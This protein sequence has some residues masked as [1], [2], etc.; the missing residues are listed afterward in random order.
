MRAVLLI[1]LF[2]SSAATASETLLHIRAISSWQDDLPQRSLA[3]YVRASYEIGWLS[4]VFLEQNGWNVKYRRWQQKPYWNT[5]PL[6]LLKF[7]AYDAQQRVTD[8]YTAF[9]LL[10]W[11]KGTAASG[12]FDATS[13]LPTVA[14]RLSKRILE[15]LR[16]GDDVYLG[17]FLSRRPCERNSDSNLRIRGRRDKKIHITGEQL[18]AMHQLDCYARYQ[19]PLEAKSLSEMLSTEELR[20]IESLIRMHHDDWQ[21]AKIRQVRSYVSAQERDLQEMNHETSKSS[22]AEQILQLAHA[23]IMLFAFLKRKPLVAASAGAIAAVA[24]VLRTKRTWD[25]YQ[26]RRVEFQLANKRE[27]HTLIYNLLLNAAAVPVALI[28]GS[29]IGKVLG[30]AKR[31]SWRAF[32]RMNW[33]EKM[34]G[35][36]FITSFAL[37][38]GIDAK[39]HLQRK[40][41][42]LK[43]KNFA[44]NTSYNVLGAFLN[45]QALMNSAT[46]RGRLMSMVAISIAY[47]YG[48]IYTQELQGLLGDHWNGRNIQWDEVFRDRDM[49]WRRDIIHC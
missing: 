15:E 38:R 23:P 24:Y 7:P 14:S 25:E 4:H 21:K 31:T 16:W 8:L 41:N 12:I 9:P 22:R 13:R 18:N 40:E 6:N 19:L 47:S 10:Q 17:S 28:G 34:A 11:R 36:D 32:S 48:N 46:W 33:R 30:R 37:S 1:S 3:L 20:Q 26:R 35:L 39:A 44:I 5:A 43:S 29:I 45:R 2:V 42:P 27:E 49:K